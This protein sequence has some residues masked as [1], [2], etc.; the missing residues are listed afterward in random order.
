[1][2][3][4]HSHDLGNA[5]NRLWACLLAREIE[6]NLYCHQSKQSL[7]APC[8][9]THTSFSRQGVLICTCRAG[10]LASMHTLTLA[11]LCRQLCP[12]PRRCALPPLVSRCH[13]C[14]VLQQIVRA[15]VGFARTDQD[16]GCNAA[17]VHRRQAHRAWEPDTY[18]QINLKQTLL[19]LHKQGAVLLP[20]ESKTRHFMMVFTG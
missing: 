2:L 18:T 20:Q 14:P 12:H 19:A 10:T 13:S 5:C 15:L 8:A 1:M 6:D 7:D 4:A 17:E 3:G 16:K 9:Q 11:P